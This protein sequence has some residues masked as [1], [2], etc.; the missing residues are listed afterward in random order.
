MNS[1]THSDRGNSADSILGCRTERMARR[2]KTKKIDPTKYLKKVKDKEKYKRMIRDRDIR[3]SVIHQ[4]PED[5]HDEKMREML[6]K[7]LMRETYE[8]YLSRDDCY[9]DMRNTVIRMGY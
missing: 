8:I 7:M 4:N 6:I 5:L 2:K 3:S 9:N 1:L